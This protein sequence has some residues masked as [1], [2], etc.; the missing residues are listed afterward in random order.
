ME[1]FQSQKLDLLLKEAN[2]IVA[3]RVSSIKNLQKE[4]MKNG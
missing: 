1:V 2:E 4:N 3:I